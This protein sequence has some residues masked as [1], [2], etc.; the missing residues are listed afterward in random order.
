MYNCSFEVDNFNP[1]YWLTEEHNQCEAKFTQQTR[2]KEHIQFKHEGISH[3]CCFSDCESEFPTKHLLDVHMEKHEGIKYACNEC[4]LQYS[5]QG[6]LKTHYKS[7]HEGLVFK[8]TFA[9]CQS[10][11]SSNAG[12]NR[13]LRTLMHK[14]LDS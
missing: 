4:G 5:S 6:Y 11:F 14:E 7:K 12:L 8:C 13:H 3:K 10:E 9:G 1:Q 2:L